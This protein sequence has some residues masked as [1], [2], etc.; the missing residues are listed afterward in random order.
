M[1]KGTER[2]VIKLRRRFPQEGSDCRYRR[3]QGGQKDRVR[4]RDCM[5]VP[6]EVRSGRWC[7]CSPWSHLS[8]ENLAVE[9]VGEGRRSVK[10]L[11]RVWGR[12]TQD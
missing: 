7:S 9:G 5:H 2:S 8:G 10:Q 12:V 4:R 1:C 3:E 6:W 11:S